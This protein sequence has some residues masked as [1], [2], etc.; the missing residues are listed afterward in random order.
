M[1]RRTFVLSAQTGFAASVHIGA[2]VEDVIQQ[3]ARK[4]RLDWSLRSD[5]GGH[6]MQCSDT[7][8]F[9]ERWNC[10]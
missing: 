9:N 6:L 8:G 10:I 5:M 4:R 1:L 3:I 2:H 7:G